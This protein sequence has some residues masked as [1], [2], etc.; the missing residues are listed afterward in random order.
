MAYYRSKS[1]K[2]RAIVFDIRPIENL[3]LGKTEQPRGDSLFGI[4]EGVLR[5]FCR[6]PLANGKLRQR[7]T[8]AGLTSELPTYMET[9]P[10]LV[11]RSSRELLRTRRSPGRGVVG[12]R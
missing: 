3:R 11:A 7:P 4:K 12:A 10:I 8:G 9:N 1:P 5:Y 2:N 6:I